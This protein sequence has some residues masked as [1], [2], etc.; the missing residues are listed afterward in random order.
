MS[1]GKA[2][3]IKRRDRA[4]LILND[5]YQSFPEAFIKKGPCIPLQLEINAS[6]E[7]VMCNKM[8]DNAPIT[9]SEI[10][11]ALWLYTNTIRYQKACTQS[12]ERITLLGDAS[13]QV[14]TDEQHSWHA[15]RLGEIKA[16]HKKR[17]ERQNRANIISPEKGHD[18]S[19]ARDNGRPILKLKK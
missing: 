11:M 15:K 19:T 6:L 9:P 16:A 1:P 8:I 13:G 3:W 4:Q 2:A 5:L 7:L 12:R 17:K 14:I 10:S 18:N